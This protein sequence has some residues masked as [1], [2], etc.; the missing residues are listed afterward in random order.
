MAFERELEVARQA[1]RR[2]GELA[3]THFRSGVQPEDKPDA[4]PVTIADREC[5]RLFVRLLSEAFPDD[6]FLGEEGAESK[7]ASGRRWIIDPIDGT[8][9]FVR[10][11]RLWSNLIGLEVDGI[12]EVGVAT[13]PGLGNQYW[14]VRGGGAW[15]ADGIVETQM[16]CSAITN[17]SRSVVSFNQLNHALR[18]KR[19]EKILP[20]LS[21]FWAVRCLG[22]ALD[23][24]FVAAGSA[25]VWLEPNLKP[26]DLAALSVIAK[27]AGCRF[28]AYNG[29]DS[30]YEGDGAI[31][32]PALEPVLRDF[33]DLA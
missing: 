1:A 3:L 8:R 25:E 30:I 6:G 27:E 11:N 2:A 14:A 28:F 19:A 5:E 7:G 21:Q 26:W 32:V 20:F 12:V 9:D 4:S 23:A 33:L 17:V 16:S 18:H 10:G 22:G 15:R 29:K 31:C 13:F 24:M